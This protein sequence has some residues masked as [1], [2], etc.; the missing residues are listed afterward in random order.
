MALWLQAQEEAPAS[1]TSLEDFYREQE[2]KDL[3]RRA[4]KVRRRRR[5]SSR[6]SQPETLANEQPPTQLPAVYQ[7]QPLQRQ[8]QQQQQQQD[9]LPSNLPQLTLTWQQNQQSGHWWTHESTFKTRYEIHNPTPNPYPWINHHLLP[10]GTT[11]PLT[12]PPHKSPPNSYNFTPSLPNGLPRS[13]EALGTTSTSSSSTSIVP[14]SRSVTNLGT[15]TVL[16]H[17]NVDFLDASDPWGMRWHHDG[18]YDVGD[19]V[20]ASR[21]PP[22]P[23]TTSLP[24]DVRITTN[25][26]SLYAITLTLSQPSR[27]KPRQG[28]QRSGPSPSPLFQS[29]SAVQLSI[30]PRAIQRRVPPRT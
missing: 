27:F 22:L 9:Q 8:Q 21:A 29:T 7:G 30:T 19:F 2:K 6:A 26:T 25:N 24:S 16:H 18:R 4:S 3:E 12:K 17:D 1:P 13:R 23:G 11:F 15:T 28:A 10:P 20:S 14:R 5:G